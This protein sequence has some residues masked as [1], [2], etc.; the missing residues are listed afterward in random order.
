MS[1]LYTPHKNVIVCLKAVFSGVLFL[2]DWDV[3]S[4]RQADLLCGLAQGTL[5]TSGGSLPPWHKRILT[6]LPNAS[7]HPVRCKLMVLTLTRLSGNSHTNEREK[8]RNQTTSNNKLAG[9]V[10]QWVNCLPRIHEALGWIPSTARHDGAW[11]NPA[12]KGQ[13]WEDQGLEIIFSYTASSK[14]GWDTWATV[15][16]QIKITPKTKRK[17]IIFCYC[18]L[19]HNPGETWPNVYSPHIGH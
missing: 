18:V 15:S 8:D 9:D 11:I 16:K 13:R 10:A 3:Y 5:M 12:L 2:T 17:S 14:P 1:S 6:G 7:P 19:W 4:T